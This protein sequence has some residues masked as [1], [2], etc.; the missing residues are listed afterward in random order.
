MDFNA[1]LA[2]C[3]LDD[4]HSTGAEYT[5]SNKHEHQTRTWARLDRVLINPAWITLYPN[6][7]ADC[8][9]PGIFDHAPLLVSLGGGQKFTKNF[10][11][12]NAWTMNPDYHNIVTALW[13]TPCYGTPTYQLFY[14]L[15][16]V[17]K[18]LT[19]LHK[20]SYSDITERL[21]GVQR[22][23]DTCPKR[24]QN[25][26]FSPTLIALEKDLICK[27]KELSKAENDMLFQRAKTNN[28]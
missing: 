14:K 27:Y 21:Q 28:I 12:L 16:A 5:W 8:L 7:V 18:A 22:D 6:S 11:F 15:Q 3:F 23:L 20:R 25:D 9:P 2:K 24:I 19:A 10:S 4:M 13:A 1:C 26:L 17:K